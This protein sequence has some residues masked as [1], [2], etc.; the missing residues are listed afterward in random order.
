MTGLVDWAVERSRMILAMVLLSIGAGVIAYFSLP[1][2]GSPNIDVPILFVSVPLPGVSATDSERLMVK[3]LEAKLRGV[4]GLD[5]I[6]AYAT[7]GHAGVLLKF[8]FDWDKAGTIADVRDKVDQA[9][10]EMPAEVEEPQVIE[11]NLSAFPI[12]VISLSGDVPERTLLRLAKEMQRDIESISSVLDAGLAGHR[13]EMLEVTI[14]PLKM[15]AY[16]VTAQELLAVVS[17]NNALV[18]AGSMENGAGSFGVKLPGSFETAAELY[19]LPVR[20]VGDRMV[21]LGD[22]ATIKRTYEDATGTARYNGDKTVALQVKKR[23]GENIIETV[24]NVRAQVAASTAEWPET[25]RD[26]VEISFSMDESIQVKSMVKQ[27]EG[28][29][30][31]A[32]LL[33]MVVVVLTLGFR[34]SLLVGIAI[35]C[36]FLLSFALLALLGMSVNNMVMFGLILAVGM[37]VDGAIVVA[38]YA[39]RRLS[40]GAAP[41]VAY[42]EAA[43]RMFWPIVS[44][45]ATTLCA[46]LPMLFWPGMPGQFM[47]QLPVTLIFVL[48]ASLIVALIFLPV[49]GQILARILHFFFAPV[50]RISRGL[51]KSIFGQKR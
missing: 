20:L 32:V 35:P 50:I 34:S 41:D 14:D 37:L 18:A 4:E 29:V 45:T 33:V 27:L 24:A 12:L 15:E 48:S 28:S 5:E 25:L 8:D 47:G 2:E 16:N 13:D 26:S 19:R 43:R 3:P 49:L 11:V 17:N 51:T 21:N 10:A 44:S 46:F 23:V 39:D 31:T 9:K 22:I 40:E 1:K 7:E 36:S 42:A 30:L 38:E 6:T